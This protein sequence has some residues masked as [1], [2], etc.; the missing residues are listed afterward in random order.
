[1]PEALRAVSKLEASKKP[2]RRKRE[3]GR[4]LAIFGRR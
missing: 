3:P 2:K 1:M 4:M